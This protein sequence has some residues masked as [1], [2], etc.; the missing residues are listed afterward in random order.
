M[1]NYVIYD[2]ILRKV[3][4]VSVSSFIN[5]YCAKSEEHELHKLKN[6]FHGFDCIDDD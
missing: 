6:G 3:Y 4:I 5:C 1:L 2:T